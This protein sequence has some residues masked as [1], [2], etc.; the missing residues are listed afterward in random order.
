[1]ANKKAGQATAKAAATI[2]VAYI[3]LGDSPIRKYLRKKYED[4][5]VQAGAPRP[6]DP[7]AIAEDASSAWLAESR[8]E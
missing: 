8:V 5:L 4:R 3:N 2:K 6:F 1:M 7:G